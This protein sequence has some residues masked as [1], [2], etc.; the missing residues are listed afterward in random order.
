LLRAIEKN[1]CATSE[2]FSRVVRAR[3]PAR[4]KASMT[5]AAAWLE[6]LGLGQYAQVFARQSTAVISD[7]TEV[8][9]CSP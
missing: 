2:G 6:E 9:L 7:L 4:E 3:R 5:R 1:Y 8:D